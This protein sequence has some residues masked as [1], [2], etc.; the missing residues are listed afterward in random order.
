M[1]TPWALPSRIFQFVEPGAESIH[2]PWQN[3]LTVPEGKNGRSVGTTK[4][5]EHIARSPKHDIRGKTFYLRAI[6][7]NFLNLPDEILGIE[8]KLTARRQGRVVDDTVQLCLNDE[9]ISNNYAK[10]TT[11]PE[12]VYGGVSDLWDIENVSPTVFLNGNFGVL[13]RFQA[14]PQWP[15]SS[16]LFVDSIE[17][18]IH[19]TGFYDTN[20]PAQ[21][22]VPMLISPGY[23]NIWR[24]A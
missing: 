16:S 14:H 8:L 15:H 4:L 22:G 5:L 11:D 24:A 3:N 12:Y 20:P 13:L 18:R 1:T 2:V 6:G 23:V 7:F 9:P 17:L 21:T 19:G 10:P